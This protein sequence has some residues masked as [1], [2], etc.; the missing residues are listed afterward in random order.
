MSNVNSKKSHIKKLIGLA[1]LG[2]KGSDINEL[3]VAEAE[4]ELSGM[5][6]AKRLIARA[7]LKRL[8]E[9]E[10]RFGRRCKK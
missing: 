5:P 2:S 6:P 8:I 3:D 1:M 7:R 9:A 4:S 10:S